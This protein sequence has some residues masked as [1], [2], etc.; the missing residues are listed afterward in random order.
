[1]HSLH[2]HTILPGISDKHLR[3]RDCFPNLVDGQNINLKRFIDRLI[4]EDESIRPNFHR[5]LEVRLSTWNS[6]IVGRKVSSSGPR[7][8]TQERSAG[9]RSSA[10][11]MEQVYNKV[12]QRMQ[13]LA[14]LKLASYREMFNS[15]KLRHSG[16]HWKVC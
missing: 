10:G 7:S 12:A 14:V 11:N 9:P 3:G 5:S 4:R 16:I 1:M 8:G 13:T 6:S 2:L 15:K